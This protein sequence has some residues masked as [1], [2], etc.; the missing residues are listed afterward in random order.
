MA[1]LLKFSLVA[2]CGFVANTAA[3]KYIGT[4]SPFC[5]TATTAGCA[6]PSDLDKAM[7]ICRHH[8]TP[9]TMQYATNPPSP[10]IEYESDWKACVA[11]ETKWWQSEQGRKDRERIEQEKRDK[12]FVE[13]IAKEPK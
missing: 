7:S 13:R 6:A 11:V 3:A 10:V 2:L 1:K 4:L 12:E 5:S 8:Q 9:S